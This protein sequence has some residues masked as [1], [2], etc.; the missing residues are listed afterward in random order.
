MQAGP[1]AQPQQPNA[2]GPGQAQLQGPGEEWKPEDS[3]PPVAQPVGGPPGQAG[4]HITSVEGMLIPVDRPPPAPDPPPGAAGQLLLLSMAARSRRGRRQWGDGTDGL[5]LGGARRGGGGGSV[6]LPGGPR[7]V[8]ADLGAH[9]S[10]AAGP[11][12]RAERSSSSRARVGRSGSGR[13][14]GGMGSALIT[15]DEEAGLGGRGQL[16]V[17]AVSDR[18]GAAAA[19]ASGLVPREVAAQLARAPAGT[20]LLIAA[21]PPGSGLPTLVAQRYPG[22][23]VSGWARLHGGR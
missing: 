19:A 21:A 8:A 11:G 22:G 18:P 20:A 15:I 9:G 13:T 16:A 1:A 3:N 2:Q 4:Q 5:G 7:M 14:R 6:A 23:W 12:G 10:A 17:I